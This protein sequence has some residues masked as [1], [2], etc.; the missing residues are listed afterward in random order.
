VTMMRVAMA[1]TRKCQYGGRFDR[2]VD[3][4]GSLGVHTVNRPKQNPGIGKSEVR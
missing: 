2:T 4:S 3:Y 1:W